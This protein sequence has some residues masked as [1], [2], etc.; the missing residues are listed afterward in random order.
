MSTVEKFFSNLGGENYDG[1]RVGSLW[2]SVFDTRPEDG[3]RFF[4]QDHVRRHTR[5]S[6]V[7]NTLGAGGKWDAMVKYFPQNFYS[8]LM[9]SLNIWSEISSSLIFS[10]KSRYTVVTAGCQS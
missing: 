8:A 9:I 1:S 2:L 4:E 10:E 7:R 5:S 6:G 3:G